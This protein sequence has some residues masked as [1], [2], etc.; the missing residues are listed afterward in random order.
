MHGY[1]W[2]EQSGLILTL[3]QTVFINTKKHKLTK[4]KINTLVVIIKSLECLNV[5]H[6]S[7]VVY[8]NTNECDENVQSCYKCCSNISVPLQSALMAQQVP[9]QWLFQM[10]P[11]CTLQFPSHQSNSD[12]KKGCGVY[13][14]VLLYVWSSF[15]AQ[16]LSNNR[17]LSQRQQAVYS[18]LDSSI[19]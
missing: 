15:P 1:R 7:A 3:A 10:M 6:N 2:S 13:V 18:T 14:S 12:S 9:P 11:L 4:T 5:A 17:V 19:C 16:V 8:T